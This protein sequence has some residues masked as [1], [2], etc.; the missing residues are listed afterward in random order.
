ME[1]DKIVQQEKA[2]QKGNLI[3]Y[4]K[5]HPFQVYN[6]SSERKHYF[7]FV[8]IFLFMF[9]FLLEYNIPDDDDDYVNNTN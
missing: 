7:L 8:F 3:S 4:R 1:C 6:V 2:H 9:R 5:Q